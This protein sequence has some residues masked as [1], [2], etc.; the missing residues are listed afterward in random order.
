VAIVSPTE[1]HPAGQSAAADGE[2]ARRS[3][4]S[5]RQAQIRRL[6]HAIRVKTV[7]MSAKLISGRQPP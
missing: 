6:V 7:K 5:A 2:R 3:R 4:R 1:D